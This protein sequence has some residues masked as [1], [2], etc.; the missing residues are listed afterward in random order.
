MPTVKQL[1]WERQ[2]N[3][4]HADSFVDFLSFYMITHWNFFSYQ[5]MSQ[6]IIFLISADCNILCEIKFFIR[7]KK[8]K[9]SRNL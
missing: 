7:K 1:S 2:K 9:K 6:Q 8:E 4:Y 5:P 3:C